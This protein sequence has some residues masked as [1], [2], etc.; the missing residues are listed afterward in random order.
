MF[1][2]LLNICSS[3]VN[4]YL[5]DCRVGSF[6][7]APT[8]SSCSMQAQ[9]LRSTWDLP[10]PGVKP[11]TLH[12][13]VDSLPLSCH[14]SPWTLALMWRGTLCS[15]NKFLAKQVRKICPAGL[16]PPRL[17][18]GNVSRV[19]HLK[20]SGRHITERNNQVKIMLISILFNPVLPKYYPI[21]L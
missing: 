16:N 13:Q 2:L 17:W 10:G 9:L 18:T 12:W 3:T 4:I 19:G 6:I 20:S 8:L 5:F 21:N 7:A 11:V 1:Y 15:A 14:G